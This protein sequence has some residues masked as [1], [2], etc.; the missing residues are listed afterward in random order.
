MESKAEVGGKMPK[1]NTERS[2]LCIC[3][4]IYPPQFH[5]LDFKNVLL[6][7]FVYTRIVIKKITPQGCGVYNILMHVK[8]GQ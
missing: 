2:E 7:N 5:W 3:L 1:G 8:I 4:F 6:L